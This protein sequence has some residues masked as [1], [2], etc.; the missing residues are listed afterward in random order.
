GR[1]VTVRGVKRGDLVADPRDDRQLLL[2]RRKRLQHLAELQ[3]V[4]GQLGREP[5]LGQVALALH[6]DHQSKRRGARRRSATGG[7]LEQRQRERRTT[8]S[9]QKSASRQVGSH[10]FG[11]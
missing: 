6:V 4:V 9:S 5:K 10:G 11:S 3:R 2:V 1:V 8:R 7:A